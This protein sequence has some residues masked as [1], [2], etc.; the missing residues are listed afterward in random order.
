MDD[1][2]QLVP[3]SIGTAKAPLL[4]PFAIVA[5]SLIGALAWVVWSIRSDAERFRGEFIH[6]NLSELAAGDTLA[7][8]RRLEALS[9]TISWNCIRGSRSGEP[10]YVRELGP[11]GDGLFRRQVGLSLPERPDI[12][13]TVT[14]TARRDVVA[15]GF[16]LA[17]GQLVLL[18]LLARSVRTTERVKLASTLT[19]ERTA[20]RLNEAI[21]RASQM[22]AHDLKKPFTIM[23]LAWDQLERRMGRPA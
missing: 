1:Q 23:R 11:C 20:A 9:T 21:A 13:V 16:F 10:F 2:P 22:L 17:S 6:Q 3:Q 7:L 12:S 19:A 4:G 14:V 18:G 8:S 5:A 15:L